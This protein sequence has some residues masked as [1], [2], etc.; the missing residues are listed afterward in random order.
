MII[1]DFDHPS[2]TTASGICSR[3]SIEPASWGVSIIDILFLFND[4]DLGGCKSFQMLKS[5][6]ALYAVDEEEGDLF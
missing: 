6:R 3:C 2:S 4:L 5:P 1:A